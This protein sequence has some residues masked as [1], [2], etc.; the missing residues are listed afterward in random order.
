[1]QSQD[2]QDSHANFNILFKESDHVG[3]SAMCAQPL[4]A[5][6]ESA[7]ANVSDNACAGAKIAGTHKHPQQPLSKEEKVELRYRRELCDEMLSNEVS[8][9]VLSA[10]E[11]QEQIR[12][13]SNSNSFSE[14]EKEDQIFNMTFQEFVL[15]MS[16]PDGEGNSMM[17]M[18]KVYGML[19]Q[20]DSSVESLKGTFRDEI[21][22][23]NQL[24]QNR[25]QAMSLQMKQEVQ[26]ERASLQ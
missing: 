4:R 10:G 18:Q 12:R 11:Q 7:S 24:C 5:E 8:E 3:T 1:M 21:K 14:P 13:R 20:I 6:G 16:D 23:S 25:L 2:S 26:M 9:M 15:Q 19:I 22:R 17:E